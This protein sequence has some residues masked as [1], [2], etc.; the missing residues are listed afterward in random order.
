VDTF[1]RGLLKLRGEGDL[2]EILFTFLLTYRTT[3][4]LTLPITTESGRDV[5]G[6]QA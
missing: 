6:T 4:C 2:G 5:P 1:K 3:P